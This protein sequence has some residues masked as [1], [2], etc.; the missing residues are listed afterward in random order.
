MADPGAFAPICRTPGTAQIV[1]YFWYVKRVTWLARPHPSRGPLVESWFVCVC[2][3][4]RERYNCNKTLKNRGN[5]YF[6][7]PVGTRGWS[8]RSVKLTTHLHIVPR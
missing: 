1:S 8:G 6:K 2:V 7:S 4:E 5:L 3:W